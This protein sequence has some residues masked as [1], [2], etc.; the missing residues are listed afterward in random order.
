MCPVCR[1]PGSIS[2]LAKQTLPPNYPP[3][4]KELLIDLKPTQVPRSRKNA[5]FGKKAVEPEVT[6]KQLSVS[7]SFHRLQIYT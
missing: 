3:V 7:L 1:A 4:K 6:S 5:N 2:S